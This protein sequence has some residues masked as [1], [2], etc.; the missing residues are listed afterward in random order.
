MITDILPIST[1]LQKYSFFLSIALIQGFEM[2]H[3]I[4]FHIFTFPKTEIMKRRTLLISGIAFF[5]VSSGTLLK[6]QINITQSDL[7]GIGSKAVMAVDN[8]G[9]LS[10]Q[11][12]SNAPQTWNYSS[13]QNT[14]TN[15]FLFV[16]P[17]TTIYY[18]AFHSSN[19]ADSLIFAPGYTY[20]ASSPSNFSAMGYGEVMYG[21]AI[22]INIRPYFEQIS[23]PATYGTTDGGMSRGDTAM[24]INYLGFDSGKVVVIIHYADTV[25]AFGTMTTPYGTQSVI[26]QKHYDVT[27]DSLLVHSSRLGWTTYQAT[28]TKNYIYRWYANGIGYYFVTMQMDHTNAHDST[29]QWYDGTN[30]GIENISASRY[31]SV[32]PN[33]CNTQI[34]FNCSSP[35]AKEVSLFDITGRELSK[36]EMNNGVLTM[37]TSAYSTG[38]YF[39][40]VSDASGNVLDRGKFIVQ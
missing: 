16:N 27:V 14:Q 21:Y 34:A 18:S 26:R 15:K 32:Y 13:L 36:K 33:P 2:P 37:S 7:P 1:L 40:Q 9:S 31:T 8:S 35:A 30:T 6:A 4:N 5:F 10:P 19:L 24:A 38:M 17:A 29:V 12:A 11:G 20:L 22:G 23:F 39:Y 28:T 3:L 25:D